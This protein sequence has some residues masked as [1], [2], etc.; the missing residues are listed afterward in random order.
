MSRPKAAA[1][2]EATTRNSSGDR[3]A[4][5]REISILRK[6]VQTLKTQCLS[7]LAQA[8][9][10]SEREEAALVQARESVES[11]QI[12]T[13]KLNQAAQREEYMLE[14]MTTASQDMMGNFFESPRAETSSGYFN[15]L[16]LFYSG[17][18]SRRC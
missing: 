5:S 18:M 1:C 14:L 15:R 2:F 16:T 11:A 17:R 9:K 3:G 13:L 7:A 12:A 8:K 6:E 4:K 10:S